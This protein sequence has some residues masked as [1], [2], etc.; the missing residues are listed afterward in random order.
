MEDNQMTPEQEVQQL[1]LD[2]A[3]ENGYICSEYLPNI[4]KAKVRFFC[5]DGEF[6]WKRCPCNKDNPNQYC[7]SELCKKEIEENGVCHCNCYKKLI[8]KKDSDVKKKED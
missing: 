7:G 3:K 4:A 5:K 8:S 6:N 2:F 1:M